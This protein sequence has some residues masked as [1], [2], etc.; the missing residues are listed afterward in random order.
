MEKNLHFVVPLY[1]IVGTHINIAS[2]S[3]QRLTYLRKRKAYNRNRMTVHDICHGTHS[4]SSKTKSP[5]MFQIKATKTNWT[6]CFM[7][8]FKSEKKHSYRRDKIN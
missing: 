1:G 2:C 3:Q 4:Q 8:Y 5:H 6:I 7:N